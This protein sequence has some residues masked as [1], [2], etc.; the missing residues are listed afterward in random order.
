MEYFFIQTSKLKDGTIAPGIW[1]YDTIN[2]AM[3]VMY[4]SL[5]SAMANEDVVIHS[6]LIIDMAGSVHKQEYWMK[7]DVTLEV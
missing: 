5:A 1:K 4:Q 3:M 6:C 7:P 2:Q